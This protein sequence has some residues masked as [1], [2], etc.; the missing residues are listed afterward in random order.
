MS[1]NRLPEM[2][3]TV[4]TMAA[5][6]H[7]FHRSQSNRVDNADDRADDEHDHGPPD[8]PGE[9]H[10]KHP[11]ELSQE[12]THRD[13]KLDSGCGMWDNLHG[14]QFGDDWNRF[15]GNRW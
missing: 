12:R 2:K 6:R 13:G 4:P 14:D 8:A 3:P 7:G 11:S 5:S 10:T 15:P 9:A 1:A